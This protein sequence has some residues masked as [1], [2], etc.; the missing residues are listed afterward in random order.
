LSKMVSS[1]FSVF[2][3]TASTQWLERSLDDS[4][5]RRISFPKMFIM[6]DE[7][8]KCCINLIDGSTFYDRPDN[9]REHLPHAV[10][11]WV[12]TKAVINGYDRVEIHEKMRH[13]ANSTLSGEQLIN[14]VLGIPELKGVDTK[15]ARTI[16]THL[17]NSVK[18]V[19]HFIA[20]TKH[21]T[22]LPLCTS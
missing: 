12:V 20:C 17:G 18:Q 15:E 7:I 6:V 16:K 19:E 5:N 11:E 10:M 4:A 21:K 3:E 22:H 2:V 9:V 14:N 8:I 13:A 1:L